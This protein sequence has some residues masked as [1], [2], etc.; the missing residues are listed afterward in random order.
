MILSQHG[1][2]ALQEMRQ[3]AM[4]RLKKY[5]Y[6]LARAYEYRMLQKYPGDL[7]LTNLFSEMQALVRASSNGV[8]DPETYK[9]PRALPR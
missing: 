5:Q 3:K 9:H 8:L 7:T 4:H 2:V 1:E 6:L